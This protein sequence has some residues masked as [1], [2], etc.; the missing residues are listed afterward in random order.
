MEKKERTA[1]FSILEACS[2]QEDARWIHRPGPSQHVYG[3]GSLAKEVTAG[4]M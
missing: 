1:G 3:E 4:R 2:L